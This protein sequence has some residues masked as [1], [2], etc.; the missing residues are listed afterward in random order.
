MQLNELLVTKVVYVCMYNIWPMA[1]G[2]NVYRYE[3][4]NLERCAHNIIIG[5]VKYYSNK[6][7]FESTI[8]IGKVR[9]LERDDSNYVYM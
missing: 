5:N 2:V 3:D 8:C 9:C 1:F 4:A 7:H 6:V